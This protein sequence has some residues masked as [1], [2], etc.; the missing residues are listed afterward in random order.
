MKT[1]VIARQPAAAPTVSTGR[2]DDDKDVGDSE[3]E[4]LEAGES[5]N[6]RTEREH[7]RLLRLPER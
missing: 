1:E 4:R 2:R 5:A 7:K 6:C 3:L